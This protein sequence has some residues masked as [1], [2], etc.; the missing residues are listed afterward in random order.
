L[1]AETGHCLSSVTKNESAAGYVTTLGL[2]DNE[3]GKFQRTSQRRE[4]WRRS[5]DPRRTR[6]DARTG[7]PGRSANGV[8]A[9][10]LDQGERLT[11]RRRAAGAG[12]SEDWHALEYAPVR[13]SRSSQTAYKRRRNVMS[14]FSLG[15]TPHHHRPLMGQP[16]TRLPIRPTSVSNSLRKNRR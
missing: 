12:E 2:E 13:T 4:R 14:I 6:G 9:V 3:Q 1:R 7:S 11:T 8:H 5:W 16:T 15:R 10:D